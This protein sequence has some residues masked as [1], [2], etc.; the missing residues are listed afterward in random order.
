MARPIRK[1]TPYDRKNTSTASHSGR[2]EKTVTVPAAA[3]GRSHRY[4]NEGR[5]ISARMAETAARAKR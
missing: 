5:M 4:E 2:P 3:E 1:N